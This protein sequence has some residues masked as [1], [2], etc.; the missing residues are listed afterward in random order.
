MEIEYNSDVKIRVRFHHGEASPEELG[1]GGKAKV[2]RYTDCIVEV[3]DSTGVV[4][5][6]E[7]YVGRAI[8][9]ETDN[10]RRATG[11][12]IALV[13]A[14]KQLKRDVRTV[15]WNKYLEKNGV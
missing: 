10:F 11:R 8:C 5:Y 2:L 15:I 7:G 1:V 6:T 4:T 12:K 9:S 14:V 13:D 3:E